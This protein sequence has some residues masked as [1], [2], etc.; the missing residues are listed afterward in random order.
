MSEHARRREPRAPGDLTR[1]LLL[2]PA[3]LA[4]AAAVALGGAM[5]AE[6]GPYRI[7]DVVVDFTLTGVDG[8]EHALSQRSEAGPVVLVFF[9]GAW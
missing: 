7:G 8:G 9:R 6:Q 1:P 2:A 5:P 4:L 3:A